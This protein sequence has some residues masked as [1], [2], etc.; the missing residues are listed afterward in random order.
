MFFSGTLG[1]GMATVDGVAFPS[2]T[3]GGGLSFSAPSVVIPSGASDFTVA[4]S[5]TFAGALLGRINFNS[6]L[7][8]T[9]VSNS[10]T[11]QG[12]GHRV[13]SL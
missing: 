7:E 8:Q 4:G 3:W 13:L 1:P 2:L 11:G 12:H 10:L 9:V 6:E 5:F